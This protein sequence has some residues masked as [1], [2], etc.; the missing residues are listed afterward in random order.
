MNQPLT[1]LFARGGGG[2]GGGGDGWLQSTFIDGKWL[3]TLAPKE[4]N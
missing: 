2:G 4:G 1:I 3:V